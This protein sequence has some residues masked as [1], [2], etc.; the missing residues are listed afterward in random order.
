MFGCLVLPHPGPL[1]KGEGETLPVFW[2]NHDGLLV[3]G[4]RILLTYSRAVPSPWGEGQGERETALKYLALC[5][6]RV[7]RVFRG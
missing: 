5:S 6:L 2:R 1:P 7:V 4:S 3:H